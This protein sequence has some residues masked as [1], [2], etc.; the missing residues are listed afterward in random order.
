M[1]RAKNGS[2][3]EKGKCDSPKIEGGTDFKKCDG[4]SVVLSYY[5][6]L[7]TD[8]KY[9]RVLQF[10]R[11]GQTNEMRRAKKRRWGTPFLNATGGS[12]SHLAWS[13]SKQNFII[14]SKV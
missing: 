2:E 5:M 6:A 13:S 1:R 7:S 3:S 12:L 11:W 14:S 4:G 10:C 8:K 9:Y